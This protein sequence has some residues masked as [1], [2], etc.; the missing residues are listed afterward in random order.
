MGKYILKRIVYM[1]FVF[2]V[3]SFVLFFLY[4]MIPGDPARAQLEPVKQKLSAEEYQQRYEQLRKQMGLDDPLAVRYGK[5]I[6]G[7]VR[8]D[9]GNSSVYKLPVIEVVKQ[10]LKNTIFIN[11]FAIALALGITIPLGIYCAVKRNSIFDKIIQVLTIVGYSIPELLFVYYLFI[12]LPL[13]WDG[14]LLV[15]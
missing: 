5:W 10:P 1:V 15:E 6:S 13:Y 11:V 2:F 3:M 4:N 12:C 7:I 14:S 9:L 8:G